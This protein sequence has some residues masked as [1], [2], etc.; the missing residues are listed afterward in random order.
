M[1]Y[2]AALYAGGRIVTGGNHGDAFGKL[3][4]NEQDGDISSGF[5]DSQTGCFT[6][7]EFQFYVKKIILIR[8]AEA[9]AE[10]Y[11]CHKWHCSYRNSINPDIND[12]GRLQCLKAANFLMH[13]IPIHYYVAYSCDCQRTKATA[14][15]ICGQLGIP[16]QLSNRFC[17]CLEGET[18][19]QFMERLKEDIESLPENSIII[20]HS[21]FIVNL[22]QLAMGTD[23]TQCEQWKNKIPNC[24]ITY[25]ENNRPIWIGESPI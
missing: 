7:D 6:T 3:S 14:I 18:S 12:Y 23:I 16:L 10:C 24:S 17:D 19:Y 4:R 20:S 21:D 9:C 13:V 2:V 25:V 22:A 5:L 8:H 15:S 11:Q 1:G